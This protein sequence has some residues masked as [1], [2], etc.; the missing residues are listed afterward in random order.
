MMFVAEKKEG[1]LYISFS[2]RE[3]F[4]M[5]SCVLT[6]RMG[7][8]IE[9]PVGIEKEV[10]EEVREYHGETEE[11]TVV[12]GIDC[13]ETTLAFK[14]EAKW[15]QIRPFFGKQRCFSHAN[16]LG[17]ELAMVLPEKLTA[18]YQHKNWW[19]RPA[20]VTCKEEIPERTQLLL[21]K[22]GDTYYAAM[23]LSGNQCRADIGMGKEGIRINISSN[24]DTINNLED[25]MLVIAAG[26]NP[27]TCCEKAA[28]KALKVM[29]QEKMYRKERRYPEIFEY[30]GWCSWD[31][32]YQNVSEQ[33]ILEKLE[34]LKG[35]KIPVKWVLIDDGWLDADYEA[36]VLRGLDAAMD[37]FPEGLGSIV[38]KMKKDYN[39]SYVG[40]W[41]AVMGYWNGIELGSAVSEK[42]APFL[43]VLSDGRCIPRAVQG[44][45]F[46]F[47]NEWHSYL[48]NNCD[49]DFVKIDGQSAVSLFYWGLKTYAEAS[50]EM[51]KGIGG[52]VAINF[53]NNIINCM[54]MAPEDMWH[55]P[56]SAISR[57]SDDFVPDLSHGFREHAIQNSY[58][59]LL[60]GQLYWGD[61]D[62]FWSN[63]EENWQ[64]SILRAVSGGPV[65]ISDAVGQTNPQY[66]MPL[67]LEDG[68]LLRC[69]DIGVPTLDCLFEDP[70]NTVKPLKIFNVYRESYIVAALNVNRDDK[71][72]VGE[73]KVTDIP[74]LERKAWWVY[75]WK[76]E[77]LFKLTEHISVDYS[78]C[79]NDGELFLFIP[80]D[81][82]E[83]EVVPIGLVD[84][85]LS[86]ATIEKVKRCEGKV[87]VTLKESGRFN[88]ISSCEPKEVLVNG[89]RVKVEQ[90][91]V[92]LWEIDCKKFKHPLIEL[93]F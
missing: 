14:V 71:D 87:E 58:N 70:I 66:I 56:S 75:S 6:D 80:C 25:V 15:K 44:D 61:W 81:M 55:R 78:L 35:K 18:V 47:W 53:N 79:A 51:Q 4:S 60:Q 64:N 89:E 92:L 72:C 42:M 28:K 17:F 24:C 85:Y 59:S 31:A 39:I 38:A 54:G 48:K 36:Q 74:G 19:L 76:S 73:L 41:Q 43:E 50:R 27:Y 1:N 45:A 13:S 52:S 63:H 82:E 83:K 86:V 30:F 20:F 69:E 23:A 46:S 21:W 77:K 34:E 91:D 33:G 49:I 12:V 3:L 22:E 68:K 93:C 84:K 16:S 7:E 29:G 40:V 37:K 10:R 57:S 88:F 26:E 8:K 11:A 67:L 62:M 65:Y 2:E 5:T 32:F 9:C 90:K